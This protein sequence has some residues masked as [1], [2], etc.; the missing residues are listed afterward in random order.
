MRHRVRSLALVFALGCGHGAGTPDAGPEGTYEQ[1][2]GIFQRSCAFRTCHGG[3]GS[4]ASMLNL[5]M[6]AGGSLRDELVGVPSCQYSAMPLVDPGDPANSWLMVKLEGPHAM[7]R[8]EFTPAASWDPGIERDPA[9][10]R[11][12]ASQCPLTQDGEISFG[13]LMPMGSARGLPASDL[14]VI[15]AWIEAGAPGP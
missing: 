5:E 7:G 13:T 12:P 8:I 3:I 11:Y 9:T 2:A 4:G 6:P 1:V 14:A 15:R 10:G